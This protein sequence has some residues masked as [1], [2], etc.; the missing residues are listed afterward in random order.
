MGMNELLS[1]V[2]LLGSGFLIGGTLRALRDSGRGR[3]RQ[4][5]VNPR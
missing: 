5:R 4:G 2:T 3:A 1:V